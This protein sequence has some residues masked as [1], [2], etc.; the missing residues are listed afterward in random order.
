MDGPHREVLEQL[1][2]RRFLSPYPAC[3]EPRNLHVGSSPGD[4]PC[5]ETL[6]GNADRAEHWTRV[7]IP[8][9]SLSCMTFLTSL[10][11]R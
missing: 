4:T 10:S 1:P 2:A 5:S 7:Q 11:F 8:P 3:W 9:P 6:M